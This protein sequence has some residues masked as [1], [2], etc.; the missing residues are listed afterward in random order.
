MSVKRITRRVK[1]IV[2]DNDKFE[3]IFE[4]YNPPYPGY[5]EQV[6]YKA[7]G[8]IIECTYTDGH[9]KPHKTKCTSFVTF[10][11]RENFTEGR[12]VLAR[13]RGQHYS[14]VGKSVLKHIGI[15]Y[16]KGQF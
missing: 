9:G 14:F 16:D 2:V 1:S 6:E 8:E 12:F 13:S 3:V 5:A 11:V 15:D 7:I 4:V 10:Y